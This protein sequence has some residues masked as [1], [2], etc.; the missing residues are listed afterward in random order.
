MAPIGAPIIAPF[1]P[2]RVVVRAPL[3]R[4][5]EADPSAYDPADG[6]TSGEG[7]DP[8]HPGPLPGRGLLR[9][10]C[11]ARVASGSAHAAEPR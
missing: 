7:N 8:L 3:R 1:Q 9:L 4:D 10:T 11:K 6:H 2:A 5:G